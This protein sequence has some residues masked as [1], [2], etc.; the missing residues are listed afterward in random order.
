[1]HAPCM[2]LWI[3]YSTTGSYFTIFILFLKCTFLQHT[4]ESLDAQWMST[5][6][7]CFC[8]NLTD[9]KKN[10][11]MNMTKLYMMLRRLMQAAHNFTLHNWTELKHQ[12]YFQNQVCNTFKYFQKQIG[13]HTKL[14]SAQQRILLHYTCPLS[15]HHPFCNEVML[16]KVRT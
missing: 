12:Q 3:K 7:C 9:F 14:P 13:L 5:F 8:W 16:C 6:C 15:C 4:L 11:T 2:D 1:M 10:R